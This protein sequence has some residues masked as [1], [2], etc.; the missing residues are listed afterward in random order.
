MTRIPRGV[1]LGLLVGALSATGLRAQLRRREQGRP[2]RPPRPGVSLVGGPTSYDLSGTGTAGIGQLR[3]DGPVSRILVIELGLGVFSYRAQFSDRVTHLVTDVSLQAQLP[4]G[5]VRP[6]LGAGGGFA[7]YLSGRGS[8]LGTLHA[9]AGVRGDV[10][11]SWGLLG[12]I[13][14]R[15]VD[16]FTGSMLDFVVGIRRRL[17]R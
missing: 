10:G 16:P 15:S 5:P 13:R 7:E 1:I 6:Y 9:A 8:T 2:D 14:A 4:R 17:G 11:G 12:E 3:I